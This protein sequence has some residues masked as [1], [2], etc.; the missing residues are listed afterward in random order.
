[1]G[2]IANLQAYGKAVDLT[3]Q[4]M[5]DWVQ[6]D[7]SAAVLIINPEATL[8]QRAG[9]AWITASDTLS[10][11][12]ASLAAHGNDPGSDRVMLCL[13]IERLRQLE[14]MLGDIGVRTAHLKGGAA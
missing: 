13:A 2:K 8:H 7:G 6:K 10:I 14:R 12:E 11:M 5:D 4:M 3:P 1:M 9:L